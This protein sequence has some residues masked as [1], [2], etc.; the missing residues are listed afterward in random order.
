MNDVMDLYEGNWIATI[1]GTV[2]Y[3]GPVANHAGK[4]GIPTGGNFLYEDGHVTWT[5]FGGHTNLVAA[6]AQTG[7]NDV[8]Y[9]APVSI[10]TGPW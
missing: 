7:N 4:N 6:T 8:Y 1:G 2:S 10:G 9:E 5:P 3:T